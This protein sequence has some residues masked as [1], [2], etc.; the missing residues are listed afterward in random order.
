MRGQQGP[1]YSSLANIIE[2]VTD[3][4][5]IHIE[6]DQEHWRITRRNMGQI[7]RERTNILP[8]RVL[9]T[10]CSVTQ[11]IFPCPHGADSE[12]YGRYCSTVLYY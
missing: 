7:G 5:V 8:L 3:T 10:E 1:P 9:H 12:V 2:K 4:A 6:V 11:S